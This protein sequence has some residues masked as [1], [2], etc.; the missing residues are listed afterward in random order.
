[1]E[2]WTIT[3]PYGCIIDV[4]AQRD[5]FNRRGSAVYKKKKNIKISVNY[6]N[7]LITNIIIE[8]NPRGPFAEFR[9]LDNKIYYMR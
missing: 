9:S 6:I 3:H 1:M 7:N 5:R 2:R 8:G 4:V